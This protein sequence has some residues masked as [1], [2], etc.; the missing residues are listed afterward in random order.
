M[1]RLTPNVVLALLTSLFGLAACRETGRVDAAELPRGPGGPMMRITILGDSSDARV[2]PA[3]EAV[4]YWNREFGRLGRRFQFDSG[5]VRVDP[6]A[7]SVV[8]AAQSEAVFG[9]GTA[10]NR[11]FAELSDVPGDIVIVLTNTDL[12]SFSVQWRP[13]S[14]GIVAVRRGDIWPLSLPNTVRNVVAHELGHVLG[15]SHNRDS[16]TL[17]CGR[18][19]SCRPAAFVADTARF[20]PLTREDEERIESRWP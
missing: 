11:L 13:G 5:T 10:T 20:F 4:G 18:P 9:G 2:V 12:I 19:A 16:T 17:M 8:R 14:K 6:V 7:A 15:L 3:L 1:V